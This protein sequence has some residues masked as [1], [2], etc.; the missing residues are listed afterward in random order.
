M[1]HA[2]GNIGGRENRV[3]PLLGVMMGHETI[4]RELQ[5]CRYD[6]DVK[7]V[8][9]RVDSGGGSGFAIM[10]Q[11]N[12]SEWRLQVT[13]RKKIEQEIQTAA[14][15]K[16]AEIQAK[17]EADAK[18]I[19]FTDGLSVEFDDWRFNVR[20]SNT[21]PLMR[22]NVESRGDV[23]LMREKTDLILSLLDS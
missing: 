23:A 12:F 11:H 17:Y 13:G 22:L 14:K 5:R 9:L 19:D 15:A 4:V 10:N 20:S 3:D 21:E 6:D 1:V 16:L 18:S 7:A 8:V 2:Q